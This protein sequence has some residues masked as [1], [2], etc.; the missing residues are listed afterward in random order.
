[1]LL[2]ANGLLHCVEDVIVYLASDASTWVALAEIAKETR[3]C[4]DSST[5]ERLSRRDWYH[6]R[7]DSFEIQAYY[8]GA[9]AS[10][11]RQRK[12]RKDEL[13]WKVLLKPNA[14]EAASLRVRDRRTDAKRSSL[15]SDAESKL[16]KGFGDVSVLSPQ[17]LAAML[18]ALANL[19]S[20]DFQ[21][22]H[23]E[24]ALKC[25]SHLECSKVCSSES[26]GN[27]VKEL[28]LKM[29]PFSPCM[30]MR[31]IFLLEHNHHQVYWAW[32]DQALHELVQCAALDLH[33]YNDDLSRAPLSN[34]A[35]GLKT[36]AQQPFKLRLEAE[37]CLLLPASVL[38][39]EV[40]ITEDTAL[41]PGSSF[42]GAFADMCAWLSNILSR[43]CIPQGH[44]SDV[45]KGFVKLD[46]A[47]DNLHDMCTP[48][49][50]FDSEGLSKLAMAIGTVAREA[51]RDKAAS[52][53][54]MDDSRQE[55]GVKAMESL[56]ACV[57]MH[58]VSASKN[59]TPKDL[60]LLCRSF[61]YVDVA[62]TGLFDHVAAL[63]EE[64]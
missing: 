61:S 27:P 14:R 55:F 17:E 3:H 50:L 38:R 53:P 16:A 15:V 44:R 5:R 52:L 48:H 7:D 12:A 19:Q 63:A 1:M 28:H 23:C 31:A 43:C 13:D 54:S 24:L 49:R 18:C 21:H 35:L 47:C 56:A 60:T 37:R 57:M 11:E 8:K 62:H 9:V 32:S 29:V 22:T 6:D 20:A 2:Q 45:F 64:H 26:K 4:L 10:R 34:V 25:V 51:D 59:W 58:P 41:K 46:A 33:H 40:E 42:F 39:L 30:V 36:V